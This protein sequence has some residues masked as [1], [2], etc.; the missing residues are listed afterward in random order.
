[1]VVEQPEQREIDLDDFEIDSGHV[2]AV[3]QDPPAGARDRDRPSAGQGQ[4]GVQ[5][6]PPPEDPPLRP[7][8][9]RIGQDAATP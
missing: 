7:L 6:D 2:Q 5:D 9:D 1:M 3:E 8:I 4:E